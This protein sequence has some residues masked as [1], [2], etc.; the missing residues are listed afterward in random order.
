MGKDFSNTPAKRFLTISSKRPFYTTSLMYIVAA[1]FE[2]G[3]FYLL[4][5]NFD[6]V[7]RW[8]TFPF[9]GWIMV[10]IFILMAVM[11]PM[12]FIIGIKLSILIKRATSISFTYEQIEKRKAVN[13]FLV[14]GILIDALFSSL[15]IFGDIKDKSA[16]VFACAFF[17]GRVLQANFEAVALYFDVRKN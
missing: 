10:A 17:G 9:I 3:W 2:S 1:I 12:M 7:K 11:I 14:I 16:V 15:L 8:A 6:Q 13:R 5:Q 4:F